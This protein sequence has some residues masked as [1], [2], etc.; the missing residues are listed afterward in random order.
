MGSLAEYKTLAWKSFFSGSFS[1]S[2]ETT[3]NFHT[4][5]HCL[6]IRLKCISILEDFL[7]F[8]STPS[9]SFYWIYRF[10]AI[11]TT[12]C[13]LIFESLLDPIILFQF[14]LLQQTVHLSSAK[15][16]VYSVLIMSFF[17]SVL[18]TLFP[19]F[20]RGVLFSAK[21]FERDFSYLNI[22]LSDHCFGPHCHFTL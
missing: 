21:I 15:V 4:L 20:W 17:Y 12:V 13:I 2:S 8:S 10:I 7:K 19:P 22:S 6:I 16:P 1:S 3:E 5:F 11:L 9:F 18:E 14:F